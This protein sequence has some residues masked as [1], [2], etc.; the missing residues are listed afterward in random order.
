MHH[1]QTAQSQATM[2]EFAPAGDFPLDTPAYMKGFSDF[3]PEINGNVAILASGHFQFAGGPQLGSR[4]RELVLR[5]PLVDLSLNRG[6]GKRLVATVDNDANLIG[7]RLHTAGQP[8]GPD[9]FVL[10]ISADDTHPWI[11]HIEEYPLRI[12]HH[13]KVRMDFTCI[14]FTDRVRHDQLTRSEEDIRQMAMLL[15]GEA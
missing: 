13:V 10:G 3:G 11:A 14:N 15:R 6:L 5:A 2:P 4:F 8:A 7:L 9:E 1:Q 12:P